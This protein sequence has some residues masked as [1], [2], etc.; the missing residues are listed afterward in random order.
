LGALDSPFRQAGTFGASQCRLNERRVPLPPAKAVASERA[1]RDLLVFLDLK[2]NDLML[3]LHRTQ[4]TLIA[5]QDGG[6]SD[7]AMHGRLG[8]AL[9]SL[10]EQ[11]R[12]L[13]DVQRRIAWA[14]LGPHQL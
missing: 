1:T 11:E 10:R 7:A 8:E 5:I 14:R 4:Q 2:L 13:A 12:T 6:L 3:S 9:A